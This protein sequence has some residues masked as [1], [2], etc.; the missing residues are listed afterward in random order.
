MEDHVYDMMSTGSTS[1]RL[2]SVEC[3]ALAT[4]DDHDTTSFRHL[5]SDCTQRLAMAG[6]VYANAVLS[7][8]FRTAAYIF[9]E[10]VRTASDE[11]LLSLLT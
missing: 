1:T 8:L 4:K 10:V 11:F 7:T 9:L 6:L 3:A 5:L 2:A